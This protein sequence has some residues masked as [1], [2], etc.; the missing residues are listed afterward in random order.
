MSDQSLIIMF[1]LQYLRVLLI[2]GSIFAQNDRKL[3]FTNVTF[4]TDQKYWNISLW[5]N[6]SR[7]SAIITARM[8]TIGITN[9]LKLFV[10]TGGVNGKFIN[11]FTKQVDFCQVLNNPISDPLVRMIHHSILI[12]QNNHYFQKCPIVKVSEYTFRFDKL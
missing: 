10:N 9:D 3:V 1:L 12:N 11:F 8:N 6:E 2:V 7:V 4:S 5:L